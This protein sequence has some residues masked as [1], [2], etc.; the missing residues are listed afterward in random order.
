MKKNVMK[1]INAKMQQI[2]LLVQV[3]INHVDI[4]M[5]NVY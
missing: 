4:R 1:K 3:L 2:K 5:E